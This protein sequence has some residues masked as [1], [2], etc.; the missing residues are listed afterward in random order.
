MGRSH[1]S[2]LGGEVL[3]Q[4]GEGQGGGGA[5]GWIKTLEADLLTKLPLVQPLRTAVEREAVYARRG[6]FVLNSR[7]GVERDQA[8]RAEPPPH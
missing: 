3:P 7:F 4:G 5:D 1:S 8:A 2:P 6:D